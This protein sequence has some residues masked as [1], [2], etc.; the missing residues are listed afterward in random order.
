MTG[1]LTMRWH[2]GLGRSWSGQ[3]KRVAA[4][5]ELGRRVAESQLQARLEPDM[6]LTHFV[7]RRGIKARPPGRSGEFYG[8]GHGKEWIVVAASIG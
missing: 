4:A 8:Q 2:V 6:M 7:R 1:Q 3:S 5:S